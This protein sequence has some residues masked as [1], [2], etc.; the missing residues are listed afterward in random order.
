MTSTNTIAAVSI[1]PEEALRPKSFTNDFLNS[2]TEVFG[3]IYQF[4]GLGGIPFMGKQGFKDFV[5]TGSSDTENRNVFV[6]FAP[7]IG[8]SADGIVGEMNLDSKKSKKKEEVYYYSAV[9]PANIPNK[10]FCHPVVT[11]FD[12]LKHKEFNASESGDVF[13]HQF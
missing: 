9:K 7:H 11:A 5:R 12:Y 8:V 13:D 1:C 2:L 6:F 3:S 10:K 4:G